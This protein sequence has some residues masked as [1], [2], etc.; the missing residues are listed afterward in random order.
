M[1]AR[2]LVK[3]KRQLAREEQKK[4]A[5]AQQRAV[6]EIFPKAGA[7]EEAKEAGPVSEAAVGGSPGLELKRKRHGKDPAQPE[8]K[9]KKKKKGAPESKEAPVV[10]VEESSPPKPSGQATD[11]T[12][13][14]D[15]VQFSITKETAIMHGTLNPKEFLRGATPPTDKSVLSRQADD[16]LCSKVLMASVT[17]SLGLGEL[18]QRIEQ[19]DSEKKKAA[20][21]LA[22]ARRQLKEVE[23]ARKA[24]QE[25]F[26]DILEGS[27]TVARAEGKAEAEKAA[28]DAAKKA[29]EDAEE[30][31]IK[32]V[33]EARE[34]AVAT[35]SEEGWKAEG[36]QKWVA[37]VVEASVDEWVKGP[38]A[39]WLARK[40]K[41]YYDRSEYF[42]QA[43]VY[44]RLS[45]HFGVDPKAFDPASYGL[46][47]LQP[48]PR[49]PLPEGVARPDL[50]DSLLMAEGSDEEEE[51]GDDAVS[52]PAVEDASGNAVKIVE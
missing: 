9:K 5:P 17:A 38:G 18:V 32:A 13:P 8:G 22:E 37:S 29:A 48:D 49:V 1:D 31:R 21:A 44:R 10:V 41:E 3:L 52:K 40:G 30:A 43:L 46:P 19:H 6:D 14:L 4:E 28:A 42:T 47:P 2:N 45:R 26:K 20:E 7:A 23:D 51:I 15:K 50:E 12:W 25:A 24:E 11:L 36:R 39:M 27:K 34:E 33:V 16:V 35:F